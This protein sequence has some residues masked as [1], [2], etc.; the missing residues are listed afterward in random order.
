MTSTDDVA[1]WSGLNVY[2]L[3][4]ELRTCFALR[5]ALAQMYAGVD[6]SCLSVKVGCIKTLNP[7]SS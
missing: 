1:D 7:I 3:Y 2:L 6:T 5:I 4:I